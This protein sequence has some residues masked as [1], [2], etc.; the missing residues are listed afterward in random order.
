MMSRVQAQASHSDNGV[1]SFRSSSGRP[2][3]YVPGGY[4]RL[5]NVAGL[6]SNRVTLS[7][8]GRLME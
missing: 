8:T 1:D 4:S 7:F 6:L 5:R 3:V 2:W